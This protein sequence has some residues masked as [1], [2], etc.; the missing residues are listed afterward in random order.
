[1]ALN[2]TKEQMQ[3]IANETLKRMQNEENYRTITDIPNFPFS[4]VSEIHSLVKK[5]KIHFLIFTDVD[6]ISKFGSSNAINLKRIVTLLQS[7]TLLIALLLPI[8]LSISNGNFWLLLCTPL[9]FLGTITTSPSPRRY[10]FILLAIGLLIA[11]FF[12]DGIILKYT[13]L[14]FSLSNL[15]INFF[16]FINEGTMLNIVYKNEPAFVW[17][18]F[19]KAFLI[20][21]VKTG[22]T[23][24]PGLPGVIQEV[25]YKTIYSAVYN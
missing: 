8:I 9:A 2:L 15:L 12:I 22:D 23:L 13:F 11:S 3:E 25:N 19:K 17:G 7:F 20:R 14:F 24:M 6:L 18:Y 10:P 1:M 5:R 4:S 21:V 16:R